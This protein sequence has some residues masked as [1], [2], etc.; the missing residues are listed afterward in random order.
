MHAKAKMGDKYSDKFFHDTIT[1]SGYLPMS[2]LR[3]I[4]EHKLGKL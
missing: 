2:K 1:S 3:E 4:F